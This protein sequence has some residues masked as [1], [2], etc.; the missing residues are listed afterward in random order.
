MIP[1]DNNLDF[2]VT[3]ESEG[4]AISEDNPFHILMLGDWSGRAYR[5]NVENNDISSRLFE[6]DRDNFDEVLESVNARLDVYPDDNSQDLL[7]L[8][9]TNLD[10]FHPDRIFEHISVFSELRELR[11]R[12]SKPDSFEKAADEVRRWFEIDTPEDLSQ[13]PIQE[14][15]QKYSTTADLLDNILSQPKK[16]I[17]HALAQTTDNTGLSTLISKV[18]KPFL[19][20][21]DEREQSK[22]IS[23]VD[24]ATSDLMR[25]ILHHPHFKELES[26]WRGLYFLVRSVETNSKLKIF[27]LDITKSELSSKLKSSNETHSDNFY[28]IFENNENWALICGNYSF[29]ID[30]DNA[31]LLIRIAAIASSLN[32]PFISYVNLEAAQTQTFTQTPD[33]N[34][35]FFFDNSSQTKLWNTLRTLPEAGFIGLLSQRLLIRLP[36]GAK[37]EPTE[38]FSFEEFT[39]PANHNDYLWANPCFV[40]AL[41]LAQS[42]S[43][44]SW[45]M[46]SRLFQDIEG[47]PIHLFEKG[48]STEQLPV[49]EFNLTQ[50]LCE[51]FLEAGLMP[52]INY[53]DRESVRLAKFQSIAAPRNTLRGKW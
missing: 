14:P 45:E 35:L 42:F 36:F 23:A 41:L 24:E 38:T 47:L 32:A 48:G 17:S 19:I 44:N 27:L 25:K 13:S 43:V 21:T 12:L 50:N 10:D 51:Q 5:D 52:V 26:A 29:Q 34:K 40:C 7:S 30:V 22:L 31:A 16:E 6:I 2:K 20:R 49:A 3:M 8:T 33:L 15:Q 1:A 18:V 4:A 11:Y 46:R 9:F 53:R 39:G 37:T 28:E